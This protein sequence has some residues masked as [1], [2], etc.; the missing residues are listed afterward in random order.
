MA[1]F[2]KLTDDNVVMAVE[3][4]ADEDCLE[5]GV[6][7]EAKGIEFMTNTTGWPHWKKTSYN[8]KQGKYWDEN[9][10]IHS[11]QTKAFRKN[12]AAVGY[13]YD[14]SRDAFIPPK[15][16]PSW[17]LNET[18]CIWESPIPFPT[19]QSNEYYFIN[20]DEDNQRWVSKNE[21]GNNQYYWDS[22]NLIWIQI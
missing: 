8:T 15:D 16:Y 12:F 18:T 4:V 10:E 3:A 20:W 22:T 2:A 14:A 19:E 1:Y 5:N 17:I 9:N 11:D 21:E 7:S 6:E 13:K